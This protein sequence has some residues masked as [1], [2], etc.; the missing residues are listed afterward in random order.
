MVQPHLLF[1]GALV[2]RVRDAVEVR[3]AMGA[4]RWTLAEY[5]GPHDLLVEAVV[6]IAGF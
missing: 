2:D 6:N 3:Q 4:Q 5:L 1:R